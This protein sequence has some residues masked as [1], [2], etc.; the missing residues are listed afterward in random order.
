MTQTANFDE[1]RP[2]NDN[3]YHEKVAALIQEPAFKQVRATG[4]PEVDFET[5]LLC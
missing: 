2:Y 4:M 5:P 3:E 1:I